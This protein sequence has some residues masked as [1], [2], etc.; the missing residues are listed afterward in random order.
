MCLVTTHF[1]AFVLHFAIANEISELLTNVNASYIDTRQRS[2]HFA[3]ANEISDLLTIVNTS[4][5]DTRQE[6]NLQMISW[7]AWKYNLVAATIIGLYFVI[8][9]LCMNC[10]N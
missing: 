3:I 5:I 7:R 2:L 10:K 4:Y 6:I 9:E 8:Y 1:L